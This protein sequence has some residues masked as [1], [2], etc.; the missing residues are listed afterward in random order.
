MFLLVFTNVPLYL[1]L[2]LAQPTEELRVT[3]RSQVNT[4]LFHL[5]FINSKIKRRLVS[6]NREPDRKQDKQFP[7]QNGKEP[8][9]PK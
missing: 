7:E 3:A 6:V 4:S 2:L 1:N 5:P 8:K 9:F